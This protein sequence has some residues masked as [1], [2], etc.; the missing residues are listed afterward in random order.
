MACPI[1][2]GGNNQI[3][4]TILCQ[5]TQAV[6]EKRPQIQFSAPQIQ[7]VLRL[8]FSLLADTARVTNV[9]I[10]IIIKLG[11]LCCVTFR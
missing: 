1:T 2:W 7:F 3:V 4:F 5:L 8:R 11:C 9:R 10:I 6:L